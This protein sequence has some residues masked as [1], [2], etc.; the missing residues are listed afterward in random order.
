M[1]KQLHKMQGVFVALTMLILLGLITA[2]GDDDPAPATNEPTLLVTTEVVELPSRTPTLTVTPGGPTLTPTSTFPPTVTP[3]PIQNTDVPQGPTAVPPTAVPDDFTHKV[4]EGDTC[5]GIA[6]R[7]GLDV[8]GGAATIAQ[9]NGIDCRN[10]QI[11]QSLVV[12]RPTGTA[13]PQGFD[14][15]QT[16]VYTALPPSLRDV[17]PF[18]LYEYCPVE[19]DTLTSIALKSGSTQRKICELNPLPDGLD[20]SGCDFSESSVGY[21]P[22]PPVISPF[23]CLQIPGPTHTPTHTPTFTGLETATPTPTY[24]APNAIQP[25]EGSTQYGQIM[26]TWLSVGQLKGNEV[27]LV[28]IIDDASGEAIFPTTTHPNYLLP[29]D[30]IPEAGRSRN[31]SWKV[32]V[33]VPNTEGL[34]VPVSGTAEFHRFVWQG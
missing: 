23:N 9:A 1:T 7:Y 29:A 32:E 15:T 5:G 25:A 11:G 13:T 22:I 19:D 6:V 28:S 4:A 30:W 21:C 34:Y 31:I 10:L 16:A 20:C 27:Y 33:A 8:A 12:P 2:C 17:T 24:P 3:Q 18:A 14:I 26:L